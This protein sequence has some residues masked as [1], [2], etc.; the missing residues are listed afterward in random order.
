MLAVH[1][2]TPR[3]TGKQNSF[4]FWFSECRYHRWAELCCAEPWDALLKH[5]QSTS[6]VVSAS[7]LGIQGAPVRS[8]SPIQGSSQS[9]HCTGTGKSLHGSQCAALSPLAVSRAPQVPP[10]CFLLLLWDALMAARVIFPAFYRRET[11]LFDCRSEI[12]P[13]RYFCSRETNTIKSGRYIMEEIR[14]RCQGGDTSNH[15]PL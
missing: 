2:T 4:P 14:T 13:A 7:K 9:W 10:R 5:L 6:S 15:V 3:F 1:F 12:C 11:P 8:G